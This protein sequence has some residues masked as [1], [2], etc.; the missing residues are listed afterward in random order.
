MLSDSSRRRYEGVAGTPAEVNVAVRSP[1][2]VGV[3]AAA[4]S[5]ASCAS[6]GPITLARDRVDYST[7]VAESWKE[8]TLLNIVRLRYADAPT[9]LDVSSVIGSY[10]LGGQVVAGGAISSNLTQTVPWSAATL[11]ANGTYIDRP[12]ISYTPLSGAKFARNL[13]KPIPPVAVFEL[14]QAGYP[15]DQI[16]MLTTRAINGIHG[17]SAVGA[18]ARPPDPEFFPLI[19]ALRRIQ[20]SGAVSLRLD[21]GHPDESGAVIITAPHSA[22]IE[23]DVRYVMTTL[24]LRPDRDGG[25][26]IASGAVARDEHE[27]ALLTRSMLETLQEIGAGIDVPKLDIDSGRA[28]PSSWSANAPATEDRPL[29]NIHS[30]ASQPSSAFV[31]VRYHGTWFWIDDRDYSSKGRFTF[32]LVFFSLAEAGVPQQAP[33]LTLPVN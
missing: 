31:A 26:R 14:I 12:T 3:L 16:L 28:A 30:G 22:A 33:M 29:I 23:R 25:L 6:I 15:A 20:L 24:K 5:L 11:S 13:L 4:L 8:Q 21:K 17:R 7:A 18:R 19:V 10:G 9:F 2:R 32:L 1:Y 27:L